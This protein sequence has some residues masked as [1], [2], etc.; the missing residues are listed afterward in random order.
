[1]DNEHSIWEPSNIT[2][3]LTRCTSDTNRPPN[4]TPYQSSNM[5]AN[6][7]IFYD[8]VDSVPIHVL[9]QNK[10]SNTKQSKIQIPVID[11]L[12]PFNLSVFSPFV[13]LK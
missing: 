4:P 12:N 10:I 13:L 1:M 11:T 5:S 2:P 6:N 8:N 9:P 7:S 3:D